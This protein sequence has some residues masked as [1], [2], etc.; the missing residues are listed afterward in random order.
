MFPYNL[1]SLTNNL[2]QRLMEEVIRYM[3]IPKLSS[4]SV[5]DL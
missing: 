3:N 4:M 1:A 2:L 5:Y